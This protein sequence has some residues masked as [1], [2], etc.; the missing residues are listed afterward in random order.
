[1]RLCFASRREIPHAAGGGADQGEGS[2][3]V[4][5]STLAGS[6]LPLEAALQWAVKGSYIPNLRGPFCSRGDSK[7]TE[8]HDL[9]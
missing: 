1:M 4:L 3:A 6:A 9:I 7:G 2:R 8:E 5:Q